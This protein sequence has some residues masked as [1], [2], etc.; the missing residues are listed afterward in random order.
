MSCRLAVGRVTS[1]PASDD[2]VFESL[3]IGSPTAIAADALVS[4]NG[5]LTK[6]CDKED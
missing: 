2:G 5:S 6:V 1:E 4:G 3:Q